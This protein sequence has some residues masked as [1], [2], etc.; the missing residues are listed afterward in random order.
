MP[1]LSQATTWAPAGGMPTASQPYGG[2]MSPSHP[3]DA[4]GTLPKPR[5]LPGT[6]NKSDVSPRP[7]AS[8]SAASLRQAQDPWAGP[9]RCWLAMVLVAGDAR[10]TVAASALATE[11][12]LNPVDSRILSTEVLH[13]LPMS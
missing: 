4:H 10:L 1:L 11:R 12:T 8:T 9:Q 3:A 6:V 5:S 7:T 2:R 13:R